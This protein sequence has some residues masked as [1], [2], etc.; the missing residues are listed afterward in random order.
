MVVRKPFISVVMPVYNAEL[1]LVD[2]IE[3]ILRQTYQNFEFIIVDDASTDSSWKILKKYAAKESRIKI[4]RNFY[5]M[6]AAKT[7][8]RAMQLATGD[9]IARMDADDISLPSRFEKQ[10]AY[11]QSHRKT[12]A[13]GGQCILIDKNGQTIGEKRFPLTFK[14]IYKYIF[15]FCPAQQP[16]LMIAKNRLPEGFTYYNH[17]LSPVEDVEFLFKLFRY[18]RVENVPDYLLMYR[19]HGKNSS[20]ISFK[21]S[22]A[23]TLL[24]RIRAVVLHGYRPTAT[25][26]FMTIAQTIAVLFLPQVV[27][28]TLYKVIRRVL[29]QKPPLSFSPDS[30]AYSKAI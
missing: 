5:T 4:Y 13:V 27:T 26:V 3:S 8:E 12:I 30:F 22:F 9:F 16:T 18:G 28:F 17:D 23:L 25:G 15:Q 1:Y 2:A 10:I 11:L 21:K 19:I 20:L 7:V 14:E 6:K 29:F 24:S